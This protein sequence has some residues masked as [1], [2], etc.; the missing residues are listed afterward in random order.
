MQMVTSVLSRIC[1]GSLVLTSRHENESAAISEKQVTNTAHSGL[2]VMC[3][4]SSLL[5]HKLILCSVNNYG[6]VLVCLLLLYLDMVN[7]ALKQNNNVSVVILR[8][9]IFL[10][11]S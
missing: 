10:K 5:F 11:T 1:C 9:Q 7:S 8:A 2:L 4:D 3:F 6:N